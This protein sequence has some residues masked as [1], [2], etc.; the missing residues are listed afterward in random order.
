VH[1]GLGLV[2]CV[3]RLTDLLRDRLG[4]GNR[5]RKVKEIKKRPFTCKGNWPGNLLNKCRVICMLGF[6]GC[7]K[8]QLSMMLVKYSLR[9][10]S[11]R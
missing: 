6:C 5:V 1:Y 11:L 7:T 8:R 9:S 2:N 4:V 10:R 3:E